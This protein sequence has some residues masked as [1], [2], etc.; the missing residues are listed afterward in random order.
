MCTFGRLL[1]S[2]LVYKNKL[3]QSGKKVAAGVNVIV[4]GELELN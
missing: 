1:Y 2:F 4:I 3:T